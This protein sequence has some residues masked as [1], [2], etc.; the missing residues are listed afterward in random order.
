[1]F[2]GALSRGLDVS[3]MSADLTSTQLGHVG[4]M[5]SRRDVGRAWAGLVKCKPHTRQFVLFSA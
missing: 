2:T 5:V 3:L 4:L 1:M